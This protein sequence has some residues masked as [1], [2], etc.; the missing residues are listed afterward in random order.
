M[1]FHLNITF[2]KFSFIIFPPILIEIMEFIMKKNQQGI[3][4]NYYNNILKVNNE[5]R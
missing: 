4:R 2:A 1:L 5:F 3:L